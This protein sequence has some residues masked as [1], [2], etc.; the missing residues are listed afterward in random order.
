MKHRKIWQMFLAILLLGVVFAGCASAGTKTANQNGSTS[1]PPKTEEA[2]GAVK[3]E[4]G[5]TKKNEEKGT[6]MPDTNLIIKVVANGKEI[7]FALNDTS[8]S[9]SFYAPCCS[10]AFWEAGRFFRC[11]RNF[12]QQRLTAAEHRTTGIR[13]YHL[14]RI[15]FL[16]RSQPL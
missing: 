11:C 6:D 15:Q 5:E 1:A 13:K 2:S 16:Y 14:M 8:V 10:P 3:K 9:R 7:V 4:A 12:P